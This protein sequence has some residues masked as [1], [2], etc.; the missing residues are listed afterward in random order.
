MKQMLEALIFCIITFGIIA[1]FYYYIFLKRRFNEY[2]GKIKQKK[3]SKSKNKALDFMEF[4]YLTT[5]FNLDLEK[6]NVL[7]C[8]RWI[9]VID[10]LIISVTGTV[11]YYI[12]MSMIWRFLIG[13]VMLFALIYAVYE[14]FGRHLVKK[15]WSKK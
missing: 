12:A 11:I 6:V 7:Y 3:G 14:L 15:G 4:T 13:F 2:N 10:A 9:A 1:F 8:L 5:K